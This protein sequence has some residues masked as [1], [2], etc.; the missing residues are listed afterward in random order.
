MGKPAKSTSTAKGNGVPMVKVMKAN[1][2]SVMM[3][4]AEYEA[5]K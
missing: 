3:T 5:Q 1:G 2:K 4:Q